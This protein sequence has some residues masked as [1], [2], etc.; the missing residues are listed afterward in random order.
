MIGRYDPTMGMSAETRPTA[1]IDVDDPPVTE[2]ALAIQFESPTVQ[3]LDVAAFS[4]RVKADFPDR[5]EQPPLAPIEERFG[6]PS[7]L[8][9]FQV[10]VLDRP[11]MP[12]FW[13]L[14]T[15]GTKLLQVQ[16]DRIALNWRKRDE[17]N[18]YPRYGQLREAFV[19]CVE[20]FDDVLAGEGKGV[21]QPNWCE[22]TYVN[23][24]APVDGRRPSL[25]EILTFI[26]QLPEGGF[27]PPPEDAQVAERF[28][29]QED[30]EPIGR[31]TLAVNPAIRR[32]D[33][34]PVWA[35]TLVSRI[36]PSEP[37]RE[38]A[39]Q[40][41]DQGRLWAVQAF[42]ELITGGMHEKWGLRGASS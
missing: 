17:A 41:L 10:E 34:A 40:R 19:S 21:I 20:T 31:L 26:G 7:E 8:E 36:R 33:G 25:S 23:H 38:G 39:F 12:R 32:S 4:S 2:V 6:A 3:V 28:L 11:P 42:R 30:G 37:T 35:L 9:S 5:E 29:I 27:L 14:S 18:E 24:I 16:H 13:L 22:V 15:D 1:I